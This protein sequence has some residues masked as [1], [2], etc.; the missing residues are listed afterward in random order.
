MVVNLIT[1]ASTLMKPSAILSSHELLL[2]ELEKHFTI[3]IVS[4][5]KIGELT[6]NDFS[7]LF[8]ASGG[9]ERMVIQRFEE[10]PRPIYLLA[11]G[12]HNSLAAALEISA[13]I[14][15]RGMKSE[16]LHGELSVIIERINSYCKRVSSA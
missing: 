6:A 3:R 12:L 4:H 2:S 5:D 16:I 8:I 13:W 10:L 14:K 1:F 11:D 9:V 15:T 7:I